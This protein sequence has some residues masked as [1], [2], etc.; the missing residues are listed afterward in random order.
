MAAVN[1]VTRLGP[2]MG[3]QSTNS[4]SQKLQSVQKRASS[5]AV[6]CVARSSSGEDEHRGGP[7]VQRRHLVS[8][9]TTF[10][11]MSVAKGALATNGSGSGVE[12]EDSPLIQALLAKSKENKD[13]YDK[14]R[15]EDYYRRN[16]TDYFDFVAGSNVSGEVSENE[17]KIRE[18]LKGW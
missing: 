5:K 3:I 17:Q 13:K 18:K 14:E 6:R 7:I 8:L 4:G 1:S 2:V 16:F 10:A 9:A 15:L 11:A 12:D